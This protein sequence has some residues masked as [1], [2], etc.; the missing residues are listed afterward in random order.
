MSNKCGGKNV[1][2]FRCRLSKALIVVVHAA[3]LR[4][5]SRLPHF[6][7]SSGEQQQEMASL[8]QTVQL[9]SSILFDTNGRQAFVT[10]DAKR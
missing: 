9:G 3:P 1:K 8:C 7:Y 10:L 5:S 2:A 4:H 6:I